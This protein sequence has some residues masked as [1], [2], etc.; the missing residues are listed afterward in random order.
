MEYK[1]E[2]HLHTCFGSRCGVSKGR[3]YIRLYQDAGYDGIFVTDHFFHGN[4]AVD[5]TLPWAEQV[6]WYCSGF[7]DALEEGEKLGFK[8]FF[9]WEENFQHDEYLIYGLDKAWLLEHPEVK[10]WTRQ[11][12]FEEVHKYGGVVVQ[13]HPFRDRSYITRI[14]LN[15]K[16]VD[17]V[18]VYNAANPL[19]VNSLALTYARKLGKVMTAGSDIHSAQKFAPGNITGVSFPEPLESAADFAQRLTSGVQPCL[20]TSLGQ[21]EECEDPISQIRQDLQGTVEII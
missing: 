4:C 12:Q 20:L 21:L 16:Y 15:T 7:E 14:H 18:E 13:A 10:Q 9:G 8:V 19:Y 3:D 17:G 1:Y 2:T 11:Q 5:Q 6:N